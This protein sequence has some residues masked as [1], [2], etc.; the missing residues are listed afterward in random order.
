MT[1]YSAAVNVAAAMLWTEPG[2]KRDH[3][4]LILGAAT[5]P[6]AWADGLDEEMRLW[7]VG[8]VESQLLYG[9]RVIVLER[10]GEWLRVAAAEQATGRDGRGYPGW[11]PAAQVAADES[12][13][14][15]AASRPRAAVTAAKCYLYADEAGRETLAELS[16]QTTL[17]LLA[18]EGA[19]LAV[20]RP[21]GGVGYLPRAAAAP[22]SPA[23]F[24]GARLL[25][26]ARMFAGL[27]YV[28][29]GTSAWGFDCSGFALRLY[30]SQGIA[31][32]RDANEQA[33]AGTAVAA[34]ELAAGDL[35]FFAGP[36]GQ[37]DIHHVGVYAGG[38]TMIH[39]PN[40][41][42]A[43]REEDFSTGTYG[44]EY[45]GARRYR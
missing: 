11:L 44:A 27:R 1:D 35:L 16:W 13:L 32:P 14:A 7:L 4:R 24:D 40:S 23:P 37:G 25:A 43:V 8:K 45:W 28:W 42:S 18:A 2:P 33:A 36:G 15:A 10:A 22:L 38:T 6:A 3:D 41:R 29:G 12:F 5:E 39:A 30:Q 9:E 26:E 31:I 17:P 21:D 34:G 19:M 20:R